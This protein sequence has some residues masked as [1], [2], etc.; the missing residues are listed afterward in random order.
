MLNRIGFA[1]AT[2]LLCAAGVEARVVR[3]VVEHRE[4]PAFGG[5]IFGRAGQYEVLTGHFFGELDPKDPH[6][7]IIM[8]MQFAPRNARGM[9]EYSATFALAKPVDMSKSNGVLYYTVSNRGRGAPVG[10][11]DGRI[12]LLSGWQGDLLPKP[13]AETI[14][15]PVARKPDGSP[16]TGPVLERLINIPPGTTT[17]DLRTTTYLGLTYQHPLSLDTIK[18]KLTRRRAP[19]APA[20]DV[21]AGDWAFADCATTPFPGSPDQ[22]KLCVKGGFDPASEY[23]LEYTAKDPLVMGIGFAATRDLNSFLHYADHDETD[24]PNPLAGKIKWVISRGD[25]Q[26]GNFIRTFIH[27]GFNQDES[28]RMVWDGAHSHIAARQLALNIRFT[29]AGGYAAMYQPGS[30]GVLWWNDYQDKARHRSTAGLLDRCRVT[31]TCPKIFDTFGAVEFWYLRES[32]DLVGTD[33]KSDLPIPPNVRRYFFPGTTHGG[34]RGGFSTA[35]PAP[36]NGCVLPANPNPEIDTMRALTV[37]LIDWVTKGTEPPPSRYPRISEGQLAPATKAT[38]GFPNIPGAPSPDGLVNPVYDFDFGPDFNY[39]DESGLITKQPPVVK[40]VLPTLVPK[41]DSDGNDLGG[42]PSV[43]RQVPLGTYL[44]W[45]T[46]ATGFDKGKV[47]TLSGSFLPFAKTKAERVASSD[48][49]P[50]LEERYGTHRAYVNSVKAAAEKA[51]AERFLL[52]ED[53]DRLI[54]EAEASDVLR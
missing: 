52:R 4:S 41:V 32:P 16:L 5:Q 53:A 3:V 6:N 23:L 35:A 48:P 21:P 43:L 14:V 12:N 45:N 47:C 22:S 39:N 46:I 9:V 24:A 54:A 8:D 18:A 28:G 50:S 27:L 7:S 2:L 40:Q 19:N 11:E 26:S 30:E 29:V 15:V 20:T 17:M 25:S 36:P 37:A 31:K 51:V 34:G 49:R 1:A 13:D 44:G 42:V 38:I 10:S 33:A